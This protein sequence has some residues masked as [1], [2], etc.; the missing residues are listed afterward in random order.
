MFLLSLYFSVGD[1]CETEIDEC[2]SSPCK[3]GG[4]CN[5]EINRYSCDCHVDFMGY[6]CQVAKCNVRIYLLDS[7]LFCED[8]AIRLKFNSISLLVF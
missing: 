8:L 7:C 3:N 4:T 1:M 6:Q 2:S 5:N